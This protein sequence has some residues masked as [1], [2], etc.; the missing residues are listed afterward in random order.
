MTDTLEA[1]SSAAVF[2][3]QPRIERV[4]LSNGEQCYVIDDALREPERFVAWAAARPEQFQPVDFNAY[5]GTYRMMPASVETALQ[6]FFVQHMRAYFDARRLQKMHCR[7]SMVTLPPQ[8]LR[9]FQW[10]CHTDRYGLDATQSIQASVLYLFGD[11]A[12]GG[13]SFYVPTRSQAE[14][15]QLFADTT[16]LSNE[17]FTARYGIEPGYMCGSNR[18]FERIGGVPA[19]FNR[20]IF[21][22]GSLL[23]S[24][25]IPVPER[26]SEDPAAGRLTFNGFFISRRRAS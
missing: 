8:A 12:L 18:Y 19:R 3:A 24:G 20:L 26:L 4:A 7:L 5:P 11:A 15:A 13:T 6:D 10:I 9:P 22:D 16:A 17:A 25:D 21:Y 1:L 23:H 2:T 14:T